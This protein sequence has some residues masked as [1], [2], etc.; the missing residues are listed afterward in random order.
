L[1]LIKQKFG[2]SIVLIENPVNLG[3]AQGNNVGIQSA[4]GEFIARIDDDDEWIDNVKL[5]KQVEFLSSNKNYVLVGTDAIMVNS[6]GEK[7][8]TY[9]MPKTDEQIRNRMLSKNCFLHPSIMARLNDIKKVGLYKE[10]EDMKHVEDY[11]LWLRLG[12]IGKMANLNICAV[13]ITVHPE[14]VTA[15][16]R[17][18]QARKFFKIAYKNKEDY[19]NSII[20]LS[21]S[22]FRYLFF[23]FVSIFPMSSKIIYKIQ[24]VYKNL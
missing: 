13:G 11:D 21:I 19:R 3:F 5:A 1:E 15:R 24:A 12:K 2:P 8:G 17:I 10:G 14:S 22:F 16:N 9:N 18:S 20:G 6:D 4:K 7:I 23:K